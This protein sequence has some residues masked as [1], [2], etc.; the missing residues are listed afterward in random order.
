MGEELTRHADSSVVWSELNGWVEQEGSKENVTEGVVK[1]RHKQ[2]KNWDFLN[3]ILGYIT[4]V[5]QQH[6]CLSLSVFF[7][8]IPC[9][10]ILGALI[11]DRLNV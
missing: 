7:S 2:A 3:V 11:Q 1:L 10:S 8:K 9:H 5:I 6:L 4:F